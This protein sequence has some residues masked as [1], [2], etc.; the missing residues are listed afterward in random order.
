MATARR[1]PQVPAKY[2]V[3]PRGPAGPAGATTGVPGPTGPIGP[4]GPQ[5][6]Q[7]EQGPIGPTGAT[8]ASAS[9]LLDD[10]P[11]QT[12]LGNPDTVDATPEPVTIH[13]QLDWVGGTSRWAFDGSNDA[14]TIAHTSSLNFAL[15]ST[16]WTLS[17]GFQT[18]TS[19]GGVMI[20]KKSRASLFAAGVDVSMAG[21]LLG[22]IMGRG[23]SGIILQT[24]GTFN[25][26]VEHTCV[27]TYNGNGSAS[28]LTCYVDQVAVSLQ[29]PAADN[30]AGQ[31]PSNTEATVI[32][33]SSDG[34][35]PFDGVLFHASQWSSALDAG[36]V[37]EI[38]DF[39]AGPPDLNAV[40]CAA[41]L[42]GWWKLDG[43][44]ATGAGGVA[45]HSS[46][47]HDGT[48]SGG[49]APSSSFGALVVRNANQ[50]QQLHPA[51][52]GRVLTA[53][54]VGA[55]PAYMIPSSSIVSR[56]LTRP[57][58]T[59]ATT[60]LSCGGSFNVP[61]NNFSVG[62]TFYF[63]GQYFFVASGSPPIIVHELLIGG[64]VVETVEVTTS[65]T[66]DRHGKVCA[67]L[68]CTAT[69]SVGAAMCT[70]WIDSG[71]A[72]SLALGHVGST[73]T[74]TDALNTTIA[75]TV[76]LRVRMKTVVGSNVLTVLRG[77][78]E[79]NLVA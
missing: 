74:A 10:I 45:D 7:G 36:E 33:N 66:G 34:T 26:G 16:P 13:D 71:Y 48:A 50:W 31:S 70:M 27:W 39:S 54:G 46:G 15:A 28:G 61:A 30:L 40:S 68:T 41:D 75:N 4:T 11:P 14:V 23:V 72:A 42:L 49:L 44:D 6:E 8:G 43:T 56:N 20:G 9:D 25:D 62:L 58:A 76:E 60:N 3:G 2:L 51:V 64:S 53:R 17:I 47:N 65:G 5:G 73:S 69:G 12:V 19:T 63:E 37:A 78:V 22:L 32:G 67:E 59:A 38:T 52:S 18:T 1:P 79:R 55:L 77:H 57:T 24:V 21:G 35:T 29:A